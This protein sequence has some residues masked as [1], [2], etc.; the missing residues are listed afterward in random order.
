MALKRSDEEALQRNK[1]PRAGLR[2][3]W[4][5]SRAP[6][7]TYIRVEGATPL[8]ARVFL[9]RRTWA[10]AAAKRVPAERE[11]L[12]FIVASAQQATQPAPQR[13]N[14]TQRQRGHS[15]LRPAKALS[16]AKRALGGRWNAPAR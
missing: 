6:L 9:N 16:E 10:R 15:A 5:L 12:S 14:A 2:G 4:D 3:L 8:N 7:D 1:G 11:T 13:N